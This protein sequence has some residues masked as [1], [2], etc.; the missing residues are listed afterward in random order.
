MGFGKAHGISVGFSLFLLAG[1]GVSTPVVQSPVAHTHKSQPRASAKKAKNLNLTA[2]FGQYTPVSPGAVPNLA[3]PTGT[4]PLTVI[5]LHATYGAGK[6]GSVTIPGQVAMPGSLTSPHWVAYALHTYSSR[7]IYVVGIAG[8]HTHH[9]LVAADGS[10]NID[11]TKGSLQVTVSD[12][13]ACYG[14]AVDGSAALFKSSQQASASYGGPYTGPML[15]SLGHY[16]S[17][18]YR[19]HHLVVYGYHMAHGLEDWTF[20]DVNIT[21]LNRPGGLFFSG[22]VIGPAS[23]ASLANTILA[24]VYQQLSG[25]A[26]Y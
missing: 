3:V 25:K 5:P 1:C 2:I 17:F 7:P 24:D 6:P 16:V 18:Q 12:S 8:M 22:S 4:M 13:P 23:D 10:W 21:N 19:S 26:G 11:L 20:E 14:C 9:P 15:F